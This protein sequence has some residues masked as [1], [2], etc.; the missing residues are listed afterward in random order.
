VAERLRSAGDAVVVIDQE[1]GPGDHLVADVADEDAVVAAVDQAAERLG[2]LD[3]AVLSAGVGG[4]SPLLDLTAAEWDR[5][6]GVNLRGTF[7]CLR[8][9]GRHL[10]RAG[11]GAVVAVSSVSARTAERTMAHYA[12][13]KAGLDHL[14]RVAARELG[15]LGVRVNGVAPGT[16]DTPLF[17][18]TERLPGYADRVARRS[19]LG[20]VGTADEVAEAVV[21]LA[22]LSWV[23]GQI[24]VADGGLSLWSPLDPLGDRPA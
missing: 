9:A 16:T 7:L 4:A 24:L 1:P 11:G 21:A 12:V 14:V 23:T 10:A 17:A 2:G 13:S 19:A 3:L 20:R 8:Q 22:G 18:A 15:P 5:V 6:L